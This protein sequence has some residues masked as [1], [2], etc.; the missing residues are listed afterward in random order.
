MAQTKAPKGKAALV[1]TLGAS[2]AFSL[3]TAVSGSEGVSLTPYQDRLAR[4]I[5]T[6]CYGDTQA[7]M[8]RYTLPE[9]QD[10]LYGRLA[11]FTRQVRRQTAGFDTLTDGQKVA[12][13]DLA[14]NIGTANYAGSTVRR[15]YVA[16]QFPA[17]CYQFVHW[18]YVNRKD[19]AVASSGCPGIMRRRLNEQQSCLGA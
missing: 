14:Y 3:F 10:L 5:P 8:R 6:V 7:E 11:T 17:A 13:I 9:C 19:C 16:R 4:G 12:V 15:M 18:R 2:A 1:A